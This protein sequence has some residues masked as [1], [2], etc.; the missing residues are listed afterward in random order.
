[1]DREQLRDQLLAPVLQ[2]TRLGRKSNALMLRSLEMIGECS[3]TLLRSATLRERPD[4][5]ELAAMTREKATVPLES[6]VAM[7]WALQS[8]M[9]Q[10]LTE[11]SEA[12]V[13]VAGCAVRLAT[14]GSGEDSGRQQ[15]ALGDALLNLAIPWYQLSGRVAEILEQGLQPMLRD[16]LG[17]SEG[18]ARR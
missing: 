9:Q 1:M 12:S 17:N 18:L 2:W 14:G 8:E 4:W 15:A 6:A 10:F 13:A 3:A 16:A 5:S 7:G 11:N